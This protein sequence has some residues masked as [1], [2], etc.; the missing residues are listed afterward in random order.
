[1][2]SKIDIHF[3][4]F[5]FPLFFFSIHCTYS[6]E[7]EIK[8]IVKNAKAEPVMNANVVAFE[9]STLAK[10]V[11]YAMTDEDGLFVLKIAKSN[12][13]CYLKVSFF[14]FKPI[15]KNIIVS[16]KQ[17]VD[18]TLEEDAIELKEVV[19]IADVLKDTMNIK[20]QNLNLVPTSSLRD[21][22]NK[23]D[24]FMVTKEGGIS[25]Q[26]VPITKVLINKKEVFINQNKIALD[27]LNYDMM[28][29]LQL[30][31][32]YKDNFKVDFDNFT[33]SVI[34][35]N[36]KKEFKGVLK[37]KIESALGHKESYELK[38]KAMFFSDSFNAFL[39]H[40][41][42]NIGEKEFS[43][44]DISESSINK[45]SGFFKNNF[46]T[47][48]VE[49]DL[50]KRNFNSNTSLTI[51]RQG[52]K[53]K[54]GFVGFLDFLESSKNNQNTTNIVTTNSLAKKE[55]NDLSELGK[56]I[57]MK[58][59]LSKKLNKRSV[60]D[61]NFEV[62]TVKKTNQESNE[63]NNYEVNISK[64]TEN[65][66]TKA[67]SIYFNN[68]LNYSS[69]LSDKV[70]LKAKINYT[71]EN[72]S[73]NFESIFSSNDIKNGNVSQSFN[74][75]QKQ[76]QSEAEIHYKFSNLFSL[77]IG[78]THSVF[79]H[80]YSIYEENSFDRKGINTNIFVNGRGK[81]K[82]IDYSLIFGYES[83]LFDSKEI[84]TNTIPKLEASFNYKINSN[85]SFN[86]T[87][88]QYNSLFD[89]YKNLDTLSVSFNN[90][91]LGNSNFNYSIT[92]S[93]KTTF[94]YYYS[95]IA[96]SQSLRLNGNYDVK[97]NYL[98]TIFDKVQNNIFYYK[99]YLIDER[100]N[101]SI[102]FGANKGFYF[103]DKLHKIDFYLNTSTKVSSFPTV[104]DNRTKQFQN[105]SQL[106]SFQV[107]FSPKAFILT[108]INLSYITNTQKLYVDNNFSNE[109]KS[110]TYMI[111]LIARHEKFESKISFSQ[112]INN[113]LNSTFSIPLI[114]LRA[115]YKLS[116]KVSIFTKGKALLNL[117]KLNDNNFSA[118]NQISDGIILNQ[119]VNLYRI[120]YLIFGAS[121]NI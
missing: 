9:D 96:K 17:Q 35:I 104:F 16:P 110:Q 64:I 18:F 90:R 84:K 29:K 22:L 53:I 121:I 94:G 7:I 100:T 79:N 67:N 58:Y 65:N 6:Q 92:N 120:N 40:N 116:N 34:N 69:L 73:N 50:L 56:F 36:T 57:S 98:E 48:F 114:D 89:L 118:I 44:E 101:L 21:I 105:R 23:T 86:V 108:E 83:Y 97:N 15:V 117:F 14:G 12:L 49:D 45:S 37:E 25:Y 26:G 63:I 106:Y 60:L 102:N 109:F 95:N 88:N 38:A 28:D 5:L 11:S 77:E 113:S 20:T 43:Y 93:R 31:N 55:I 82:Q 68:Y 4:L 19:V 3:F 80:R 52:E 74:L 72:A 27:N 75:T 46:S 71:S 66:T 61:Y 54:M 119:N 41:T 51:R 8:G 76:I 111:D 2:K 87:Y 32:N 39:T 85:N 99:N 13:K 47:F 81:T 62:G 107:S 78:G 59:Y 42:N 24:G 30:I 115:S 10:M 91:V 112:I 33:T 103:T 70:L 1:M